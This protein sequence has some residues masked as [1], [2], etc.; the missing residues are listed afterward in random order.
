MQIFLFKVIRW[1]FKGKNLE[2]C[3]NGQHEWIH[4]GTLGKNCLN[5]DLLWRDYVKRI[6]SDNKKS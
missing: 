3:K 6:D 2:D 5:C 4:V 1:F